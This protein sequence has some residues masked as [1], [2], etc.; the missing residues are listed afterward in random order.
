[1]SM[2]VYFDAEGGGGCSGGGW[3]GD[4]G[5]RNGDVGDSNGG[6]DGCNGGGDGRGGRGRGGNSG[7]TI[8][9][10]LLVPSHR[11]QR[12]YIYYLIK[13]QRDNI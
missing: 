5:S 13:F 1:M 3:N 11:R 12:K 4:G 6:G 2:N 8:T 7:K 10:A 9:E